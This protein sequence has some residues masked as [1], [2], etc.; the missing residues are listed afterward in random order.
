M[1]REDFDP[2]DG[3]S[4]PHFLRAIH[5]LT[6]E[7]HCGE[8]HAR[9][10]CRLELD[11]L[12]A[13]LT[14]SGLPLSNP[15]ENCMTSRG[16]DCMRANP[17]RIVLVDDHLVLLDALEAL[18]SL[19][20]DFDIVGVASTA[21]EGVKLTQQLRPDVT[22]FDVD[23]PGIDSFD[24]VP[25]LMKST[26]RTRIV[27]LTAHLSD[28]FVHQAIRM[29]ASGYLLKEETGKAIKD[30][31]KSVHAGGYA[32]S[33]KVEQKLVFDPQTQRYSVRTDCLL[34]SLTL[35]QLAIL[36]HLARGESVKQIALALGRSEKSIDSH[37]YR[38]MHKLKIHDRVELARY[39][40]R[41]GLTLV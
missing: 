5:T 2:P 13:L 10:R 3:T 24:L 16:R 19:D 12:Q 39:A 28:V 27:F 9:S 32:F 37:K 40:I 1:D 21:E 17:I 6:I 36:R 34:C 41:E 35:Q 23:F 31:I 33:P 26:P 18:I 14:D 20:P 4:N 15:A 30:G 29:S 22:L 7:R 11:H 38:I 8:P 25:R